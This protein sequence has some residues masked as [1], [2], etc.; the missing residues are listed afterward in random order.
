MR[1]VNEWSHGETRVTMF[2][3][4]GRYSLKLEKDI[5]EQWY[6]FREGQIED[7][8]DLKSL[9]TDSFY[10]KANEIFQQLSEN[11]SSL[12][13]KKADGYDFDTII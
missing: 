12:L 10:D 5:L 11:R 3:M 6:K 4:N 7:A 8:N 9:L 2:H 13:E 1:I